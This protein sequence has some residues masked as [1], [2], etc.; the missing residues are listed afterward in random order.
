[1]TLT[2]EV[3]GGDAVSPVIDRLILAGFAGR[4]ATEVEHH[5]EEMARQGVPRPPRIPMF[6]PVLP[7]LLSQGRDVPVYGLETTPEVEYVLFTWQGELYVTLGNDQCDIEV[8][9]QLSAEKS[10]NLCYKTVAQA[11]WRASE[12]LGHWDRLEIELSCN[13]SLLQQDRL[14]ALIR[15]ETLLEKVAVL[16]GPRH[17]GRMIYSGT[18]ATVGTRPPPPYEVAMRLN[19]PVLDREITHRFRV[20][21]LLP[22]G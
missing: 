7:H 16:D 20:T 6:W 5:V 8:E 15:P 10:K 22:L 4:S 18:I 11:A 13:D 2:F 14:A 1:M 9:A 19:D 12:V 21:A 3:P 17:E